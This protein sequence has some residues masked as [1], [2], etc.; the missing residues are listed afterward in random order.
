MTDALKADSQYPGSIFL[1][2]ISL[3]LLKLM[4]SKDP[5]RVPAMGAHFLSEA[6]GEAG[7]ADGQFL[8]FEPLLPQE[9][10]DGLF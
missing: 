2:S 7:I 9:G 10:C 4:H 8:R 6:G 3:Y 1:N 5:T